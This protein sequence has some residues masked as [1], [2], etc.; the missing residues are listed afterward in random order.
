V[1]VA[2]DL[3]FVVLYLIHRLLQGTGPD[4]GDPA[5]VASYNVE[6]RGALLA[7]EIALGLGL[8]AFLLFIAPLGA[9]L[10]QAG[11]ETTAAALLAVGAVFVALG[12]LSST[13]ETAL[14]AVSDTN[15]PAAVDA[16]NQVQARVPNVLATAA[17]ATVIALVALRAHL[18][19]R[20]LGY[21]SILTAVLSGLGYV[22]SVVGRTPEG[23]SSVY[24]IATFIV[25]MLL[26]LAALWRAA[27]KRATTR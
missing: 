1:A 2:G 21:A 7:S 14:V 11:H 5:S 3:G 25:W 24:G 13:V 22:F 18:L 16:L 12:L 27:G 8:L 4:G 23:Q 20:W 17:L 15:Q 9:V 10:W 6:H 19:W 26:V